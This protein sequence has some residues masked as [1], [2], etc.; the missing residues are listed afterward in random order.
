MYDRIHS[1]IQKQQ[2]YQKSCQETTSASSPR[3]VKAT[4]V[5]QP[6][7]QFFALAAT[8]PVMAEITAEVKARSLSNQLGSNLHQ[9]LS[10]AGSANDNIG[11]CEDG[12]FEQC[13]PQNKEN[14]GA[15]VTF[16]R[17]RAASGGAN[18]FTSMQVANNAAAAN[19]GNIQW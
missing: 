17:M 6:Q 1:I 13:Q 15:S 7:P 16:F 4:A 8:N 10:T 2:S 14:A 5:Q 11:D 12:E 3:F 19:N 18:L 9:H